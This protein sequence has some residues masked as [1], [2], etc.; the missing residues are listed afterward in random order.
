M[1]EL[2]VTQAALDIA[3]RRAGKAGNSRILAA[4]RSRATD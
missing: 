1:R 3:L 2:A 4:D